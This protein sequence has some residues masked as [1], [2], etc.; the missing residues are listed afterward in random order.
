LC[1][2]L[3]W[4]DPGSS[5]AEVHIFLHPALFRQTRQAGFGCPGLNHYMS[6]GL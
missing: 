5:P 3:T 2:D 4:N 1:V 6:E